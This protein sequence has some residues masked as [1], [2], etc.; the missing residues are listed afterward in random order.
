VR[1][2]IFSIVT[3]CYN[4]ELT[5][6]RCISSVISQKY[7]NVEYIIIDGGSTDDTLNIIN[8]F[9]GHVAVIRS[10]P[11][12]GIYDAMNKGIK[13]ASGDIIGLLNAD[14]YFAD[15]MVLN[16]IAAGFN[17]QNKDIIY[18]DLDFV[19]KAGKIIRK[20]RSGNYSNGVFNWGWMPPHPTFYC[21]RRVFEQFG[22]YS[23]DYGTAADYELMV[24][25]MH[26]NN[27]EAFYVKRV[28]VKM[29]IGGASNSSIRNRIKV[30]GMDYK[31]MRINGILW[32]IFTIF[33]KP[34]RKIVQ[35]F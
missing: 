2:L 31:A 22:Y 11:D 1:D 14:D 24:R 32:P 19:N 26:F 3:V 9:K 35:Y 18:G 25:F 16:D 21:K 34:A 12:N 23:L 15:D 27:I 6:N 30:I 20:W 7:K 4:A 8:Q 28:I 33:L 5:I 10:E 29:Q 17:Q 13:L